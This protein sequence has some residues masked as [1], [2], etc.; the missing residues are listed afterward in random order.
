MKWTIYYVVQGTAFAVVSLAFLKLNAM[1]PN[2]LWILAGMV[3]NL[4]VAVAWAKFWW[5]NS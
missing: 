2:L 5:R 4:V 3:A 1:F